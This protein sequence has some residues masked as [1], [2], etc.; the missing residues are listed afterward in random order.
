MK[1]GL[2]YKLPIA[3]IADEVCAALHKGNVVLQAEP[4]AGKSTGLPLTLLQAGFGGKILLLEPRRLAASNVA[5]RLAS[6]LGE[7]V[8]KTVGLRMRGSTKVSGDTRLEVVTEG[9]LTRILQ[10]DP[11]LDGISVV[12]FDEFHE[13]SLHADLGLTLS[14][15]VQR[16]LREDLR[17]LL[18]SA[19]LDGDEL[20]KHIGVDAPIVCSVRQHPVE[21]VWC[22][23]SRDSVDRA[24]ARITLQAIAEH[25]G[26]ALVFLPGVAEIEKTARQLE[27]RLPGDVV[28]H[29]LHGR[30]TN[31]EQRAA[32]AA[33]SD[34]GSQRRVILSTSIA[35][36][37]ITIDG[38]R[39]VVDSGVERRSRMDST[40]GTEKLET[41]MASQASA[42]QR[43]GRAGRTE[44]GVC[45]RLW[46]EEG[47]G[48]RA[49]R[50]QPELL[51]ADLS[52][53]L[54]ELA[55]WGA[56]AISELPWIDAPPEAAG[57]RA[58]K[59]LQQLGVWK[60]TE[61]IESAAQVSAG[62][63]H[64]ESQHGESQH[65]ESQLGESQLGKSQLSESQLS[66]SQQQGSGQKELALGLSEYGRAVAR[67][68][69]HPR[70]G[71]MLLWANQQGAAQVA[72]RLAALLEE[73][74]ASR[75]ADLSGLINA[76]KKSP[77]A[78]Q[79]YRLL[80]DKIAVDSH[81]PSAAILLAQAYPDRIGKRRG[82]IDARYQLSSGAGAVLA[83]DDSL[84]QCEW[85]VVA[86]MGGAGK[87]LRIFSAIAIELQE[88]SQWC[89]NLIENREYVAWD[90][91]AERV[92]AE[93]QL[94]IG[95]IVLESKRIERVNPDKRAAALISAV[96]KKG[97]GCLNF[98]DD[99]RE[100]QARVTRMRVLEG[101][102]TLYPSVDDEVLLD[103]LS[104]W[105]LP[106]LENRGTL[107]SLQQIDLL[108][109]L[110]S[111]LN[112]E[113]QQ[114]LDSWFP[115]QYR[116]PSGS[117]HKLRY[118]CDGNPVLAVKL[119]EMFG[120]QE[121]PS[122]AAGR[123]LL[124][125]EL[126]SPARRPVQITEDLANFWHNSYPAVKKDLSGRYPKHPWPEDPLNAE[127]TARAK[128]RKR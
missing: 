88:L 15:D 103:T 52:P 76:S 68:P 99:V 25:D 19:T 22:G 20:C 84:A 126:L 115:K 64:K 100:W 43:A 53:V 69:V 60:S 89:D 21:I 86:E 17:L 54:V 35:E 128:P 70:L 30:A 32:T 4:G 16:N 93:K 98:N 23:E 24:I 41:V 47:H 46:S 55:L 9:V 80:P 109:V 71:H 125:I 121:N 59:L 123:V 57:L 91:K 5:N 48:R 110:A 36:T 3:A 124:K 7:P 50:W 62:V 75:G 120:C 77:R 78:A 6:Q 11:L 67:L 2:A 108:P 29:R 61:S 105:L 37:S 94:S 56:Q 28:L 33:K 119:Q 13:R 10:N 18:M 104:H 96:S 40:S 107:K 8:G 63:R 114:K 118:A 31:Q 112:Y 12:V 101:D 27:P 83:A 90:D 42:T 39:I 102:S 113:Q 44:P 74:P 14:L 87:E 49:A 26:D 73:R 51:R 111:L 34:S 58:K 38:V 66:K 127:A 72:C 85:L 1:S 45:Y 106:W 97:L 79:L 81:A 92:V 117:Q 65:G 95:S 122:I 82:G 116:V